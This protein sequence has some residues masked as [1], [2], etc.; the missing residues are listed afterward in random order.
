MP[1]QPSIPFW[2]QV[3]AIGLAPLLGFLGV[4]IGASLQARYNRALALRAHRQEVYCRFLEAATQLFTYFGTDA[5]S[6]I[7]SKDQARVVALLPVIKKYASTITSLLLQVELIGSR[8][9][10][11]AAQRIQLFIAKV[12]TTISEGFATGY[13]L[14]MW[15]EVLGGG[16]KIIRAFRS[17]ASSDLG[18]PR[19]QQQ[20]SHPNNSLDDLE[21][22]WV[23]STL[24][25]IGAVLHGKSA[26]NRDADDATDGPSN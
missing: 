20:R 24:S 26:D 16:V 2:L 13:T 21:R 15:N 14:K 8:D 12:G 22:A 4:A 6:A 19:R 1:S 3:L 5:A 25:T 10:I 11:A 7:R 9:T 18:V 23:D 17:A